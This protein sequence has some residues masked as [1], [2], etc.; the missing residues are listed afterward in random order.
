[1][2]ILIEAEEILRVFMAKEFWNITIKNDFC[3]EL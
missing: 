3:S 1:M 2:L